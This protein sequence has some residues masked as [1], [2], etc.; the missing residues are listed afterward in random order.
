MLERVSTN[1]LESDRAYI[2]AREITFGLKV[3]PYLH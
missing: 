1:V 3:T 2:C